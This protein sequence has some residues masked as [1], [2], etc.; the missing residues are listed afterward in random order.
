MATL[1]LCFFTRVFLPENQKKE[2][3][4]KTLWWIID[5]ESTATTRKCN[6]NKKSKWEDFVKGTWI[7]KHLFWSGW[8]NKNYTLNQYSIFPIILIK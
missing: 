8:K 3:L 6:K 5:A 1:Y 7:L 4:E 2:V